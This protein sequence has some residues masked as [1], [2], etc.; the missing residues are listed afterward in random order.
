MV[1]RR[2]NAIIT[3]R[4]MMSGS[5]VSVEAKKQ[6]YEAEKHGFAG[7]VEPGKGVGH[8]DNAVDPDRNDKRAEDHEYVGHPG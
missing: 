6:C 3:T 2:K 8:P 1:I 4:R 7:G 5:P